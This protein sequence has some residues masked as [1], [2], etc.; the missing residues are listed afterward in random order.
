MKMLRVLTGSH[1]G[2]Q[3]ALSDGSWHVSAPADEAPMEAS[4]CI[5]LE[6]W[7]SAPISICLTDGIV[8]IQHVE[9]HSNVWPDLTPRRFGDTVLCI[10]EDGADW[11]ADAMLLAG[12]LPS[13]ASAVACVSDTSSSMTSARRAWRWRGVLVAMVSAGTLAIVIASPSQ[14]PDSLPKEQIRNALAT[15][16]LASSTAEHVRAA[17]AA[18]RVDGL[19]TGVEGSQVRVTGMLESLQDD[20]R[21]RA[22]LL[23]FRGV[24]IADWQL[25]PELLDTLRSALH[26]Q[27]AT[28]RYLGQ[29]RFVVE[30]TLQRPDLVRD[31]AAR[32][33][34]DLA[35][36]VRSIDVDVTQP[37][38]HPRLAAQLETG[39]TRYAIR[40]DGTKTFGQ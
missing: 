23:Q 10:N 1:A 22:A 11:P 31:T 12:L 8:Q 29:G 4:L 7:R 6:D 20:T 36:G 13:D 27:G 2:A 32:L 40:P 30:G 26:A 21:A 37:T 24:A 28:V 17:L 15:A 3:L 33:A 5:T 25:A 9:G 16:S 19:E 38:V 35:P 34:Q 39:T 18:A 14:L